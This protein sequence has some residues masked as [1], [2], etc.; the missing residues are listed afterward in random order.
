MISASAIAQFQK[1]L[2]MASPIQRAV[3][4]EAEKTP[5][6]YL[7]GQ[8]DE[9]FL[10]LEVR[11][12]LALRYN[13]SVRHNQIGV[14]LFLEIDTAQARI[15]LSDLDAENARG[16]WQSM[17]AYKRLERKLQKSR[18]MRARVSARSIASVRVSRIVEVGP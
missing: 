13:D 10:E 8:S 16:R 12:I 2:Q 14:A 4:S 11:L 5:G 3:L 7:N 17:L 15:L 6:L 1:T 9:A 18:E